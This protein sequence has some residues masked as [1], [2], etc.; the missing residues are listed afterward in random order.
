MKNQKGGLSDIVAGLWN[1]RAILDLWFKRKSNMS[2][3]MIDGNL[4]HTFVES[5]LWERFFTITCFPLLPRY[6]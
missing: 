6:V 5:L 1:Q 3:R 4:G 2:Y